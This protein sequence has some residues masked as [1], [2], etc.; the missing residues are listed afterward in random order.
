MAYKSI[1]ITWVITES[2][3]T[4]LNTQKN[5]SEFNYNKLPGKLTPRNHEDIG[6][7]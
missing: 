7:R 1:A 5:P 3:L 4:Q 2:L 6:G